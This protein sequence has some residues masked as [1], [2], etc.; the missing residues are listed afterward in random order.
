M[1]DPMT[2][3]PL[4]PVAPAVSFDGGDLDCG[5]GRCHGAGNAD[6]NGDRDAVNTFEHEIESLG[7]DARARA[8]FAELDRASGAAC[9]SCG[10]VLCG[11]EAMVSLVCGYKAAP[12]CLACVAAD[13]GIAAI[14]LRDRTWRYVHGR[15]CFLQG[16]REASRREGFSK[17]VRPPCLWGG[18]FAAA[19][20]PPSARQAGA[21][22]QRTAPAPR[23]GEKNAA[24]TT[25]DAEWNAGTMACGELVVQLRARFGALPSGSVLLLTALDPAAPED[26]P[27]WC[28]LTGH[29]LAGAE[30][31]RYWIRVR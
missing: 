7:D 19:V 24:P 4:A 11:H 1:T 14:E 16:W 20:T 10:A 13:M 30:H 28:R 25:A 29:G 15:D 21:G 27:A 8:V 22:S 9:A 3:G 18:K 2:G 23:D 26:I 5:S 17:D 12:R 31:P 6:D